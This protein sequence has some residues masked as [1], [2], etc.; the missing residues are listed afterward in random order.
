MSPSATASGSSTGTSGGR[1]PRASPSVPSPI[2]RRGEAGRRV[3]RPL[4]RVHAVPEVSCR[5][6]RVEPD[7]LAPV[8]GEGTAEGPDPPGPLGAIA[9]EKDVTTVDELVAFL[10]DHHHPIVERMKAPEP[11][12][13]ARE[14]REGD[15]AAPGCPP[16]YG[17]HPGRECQHYPEEREDPCR[18]DDHPEEAGVRHRWERTTATW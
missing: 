14:P 10:R 12:P 4:L 1:R 13:A 5:E 17:N 18:A 3:P 8:R 15:P 9:T 16:E 11:A 2:R 7:R 6:R